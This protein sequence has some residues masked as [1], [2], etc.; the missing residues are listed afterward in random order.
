MF[1]FLLFIVVVALFSGIHKIDEGFVGVYYYKGVLLQ[2]TSSPGYNFMI[3][4]ITKVES[5][6]VTVQTDKVEE[7][8]CGTSGGVII[9]FDK[10]EVVN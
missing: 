4:L 3:P 10:I 5:V 8:P 7:I 2:K 6:Q 1:K 9:Y